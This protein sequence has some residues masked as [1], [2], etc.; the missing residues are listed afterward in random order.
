M[1]ATL[2]PA[3]AS[4]RPGFRERV[5]PPL[6][7]VVLVLLGA[8][9]PLYRNHIFYYWD[10]TAAAAVPVWQRM[11]EAFSE[12]RIPLLELDMWRGGNFAAEA[13]TGMWNPI[14][15]LLAVATGWIDNVAL[16]IT[17]VKLAFLVAFAVGTYLL[18][19]EYGS[20][21]W[22]AAAVGTALPLSG[23]I[24]FMDGTSW[25]NALTVYGFLPYVWWTARRTARLG[26]STV[27]VVVAGFLAATTG[28]PYVLVSIFLIVLAVAV[29]AWLAFD[30]RKIF[31]LF[32]AGFAVLLL[33]IVVYLP[34]SLTSSVSYRKDSRTFNDGFLSP[35]LQDFFGM[36]NP[37]AQP[38]MNIWSGLNPT[39]PA[40]YLAWFFLPLLPWFR[41]GVL[42]EKR[43][44]YLGLYLYTL[45]YLFLVLGP[46]NLNM[47][48][49]PARLVPFFFIPL[50]VIWAVVA[51]QGMQ[52]TNTK[53]RTLGSLGIVLVGAY[54][55]WAALPQTNVRQAYTMVL[56][57]IAVFVLLKVG[58][59]RFKGYAV[60]AVGT[61]GFLALQSAWFPGNY[62]VADYKF[63]T[64]EHL[65]EQR[66][67]Q[68]YEGVTVQLS[69][70]GR[71]AGNDK[72]PG[73]AYQDFTFGTNY[74]IAGVEA[75]TAYSGVGFN[76]MDAELCTTYNGAVY[77][78]EAWKR[79][80]TAPKGA[81]K[82]LA[83][84]LRAETVVVQNNLIDTRN[85]PAP[86]GWRKAESTDRVVVWKRIAKPAFPDGRLSSVPNGVKIDSDRMTGRVSEEVKFS[87]GGGGKLVFSRLAWPGYVATVNGQEVPAKL[88]PA[89]LLEVELPKDVREG[90]LQIDWV[91]PGMTIGLI[92][93]AVGIA[94]TLGLAFID[95][96]QRRR[97]RDEP[98]PNADPENVD[99]DVLVT[100]GTGERK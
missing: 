6:T 5:T 54:F 25:I 89:G 57:M 93:G 21:P 77:C 94:L 32:A 49:W 85:V 33:N 31:N 68:R 26:K 24:L 42:W 59:G 56:V 91:M 20:K 81:D 29:E 74:S 73:G 92:A 96:S 48:R 2:S 78:P 72:Y 71:I 39:F 22:I 70:L 67:D 40:L 1:T 62:S 65:L 55:G 83:D 64:S 98:Q 4:G 75:L 15:V 88:G 95:R 10:D 84:L 19:R 14:E 79:L 100:V 27:W 36:S 12:G 66:F 11:G 34:F 35:Q 47:F 38:L 46:S 23:Y 17:I 86:E 51:S 76:A 8:V 53:A 63:P 60:M 3:V 90:T 37:A 28:N 30:R 61:I 80:W 58:I 52:K 69:D 43:K 87:G 18:A 7:M 97:R 44:E 41:W 99:D 16:G 13:A 9:I 45:A 50:V 82:P